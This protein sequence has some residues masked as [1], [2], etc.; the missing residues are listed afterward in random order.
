MSDIDQ[1]LD[2]IWQ[3]SQPIKESIDKDEVNKI[4][5]ILTKDHVINTN[6][7]LQSAKNN[8]LIDSLRDM[9]TPNISTINYCI[10]KLNQKERKKNPVHTTAHKEST[11][12]TSNTK[13]K[14]FSKMK[15]FAEFKPTVLTQNEEVKPKLLET[16]QLIDLSQDSR[17]LATKK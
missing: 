5:E 3:D 16:F 6:I 11:S 8:L 12:N 7:K 14:K 4:Y 15:V 1:L 10:R 9:E 13:Y 2:I 17:K